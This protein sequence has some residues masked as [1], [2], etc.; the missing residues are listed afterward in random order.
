MLATCNG[1]LSN[2]IVNY[3]RFRRPQKLALFEENIPIQT[4]KQAFLALSM[5]SL[6]I[7]AAAPVKHEVKIPVK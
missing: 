5:D 4:N 6:T 3:R 1:L 2:D 7:Y